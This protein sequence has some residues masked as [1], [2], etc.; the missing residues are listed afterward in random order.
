MVVGVVVVVKQNAPRA[1]SRPEQT[2]QRRSRSGRMRNQGGT[3][4]KDGLESESQ[5]HKRRKYAWVEETREEASNMGVK[6]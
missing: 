1:V 3:E 2:A 5:Q 4:M 6:Q